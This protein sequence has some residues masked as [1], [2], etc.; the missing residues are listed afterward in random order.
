MS[1]ARPARDLRSRMERVA[2][3][4]ATQRAARARTAPSV[5][6]QPRAVPRPRPAPP[7][8]S[9]LATLLGWARWE[10]SAVPAQRVRWLLAVLRHGGPPAP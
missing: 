5:V 3:R 9:R 1:E 6:V 4:P 10:L 7:P 2:S 8:P